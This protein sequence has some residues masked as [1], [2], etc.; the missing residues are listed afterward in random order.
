MTEG[1]MRRLD[2]IVRRDIHGEVL[3]VPIRGRSAEMQR[4]FVL[5]EVGDFIWRRLD[6]THSRDD[7][8]RLLQDRYIVRAQDAA[9]DL[10]EFLGLLSAANLV[11]EVP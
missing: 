8:L 4:L 2:N 3:L 9:S 10:E 11:E 6:G 7:I 1:K 5:N